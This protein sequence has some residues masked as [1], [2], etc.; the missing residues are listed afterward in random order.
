MG[1][2]SEHFELNIEATK[3]FE[4]FKFNESWINRRTTRAF[5]VKCE[6]YQLHA[7]RLRCLYWGTSY[8]ILTKEEMLE[9]NYDDELLKFVFRI[10]PENFQD[11]QLS[12]TNLLN[13]SKKKEKNKHN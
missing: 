5:A 3:K 6:G 2:I 13:L 1:Y 11:L 7:S 8:T 4:L 10:E 12:I 9:G